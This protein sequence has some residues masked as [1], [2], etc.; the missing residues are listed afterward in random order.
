MRPTHVLSLARHI[1]G[2]CVQGDRVALDETGAVARRTLPAA[3]RVSGL[4][5]VVTQRL[6]TLKNESRQ[7]RKHAGSAESAARGWPTRK[8]VCC[9]R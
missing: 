7:L 6:S 2:C 8:P 3:A 1:F 9:P 4:N 5:G